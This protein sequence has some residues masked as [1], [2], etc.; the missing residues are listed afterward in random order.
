M[1]KVSCVERWYRNLDHIFTTGCEAL[2]KSLEAV[3]FFIF[4]QVGYAVWSFILLTR[5]KKVSFTCGNFVFIGS[6]FLLK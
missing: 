5:Y 3:Q 1:F 2:K 6:I 4:K